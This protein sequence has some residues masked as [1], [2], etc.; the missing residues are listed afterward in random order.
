M[1]VRNII[2]ISTFCAQN[3]WVDSSD[4]PTLMG[5]ELG[6]IKRSSHTNGDLNG[7]THFLN[8]DTHI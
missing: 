7:R 5:P 3:K 2:P 4:P 6:G 8:P 1:G